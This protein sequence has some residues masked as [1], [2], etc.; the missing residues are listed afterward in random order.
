M[1]IEYL[2]WSK[3]KVDIL[4]Y[5]IFKEEWLSARELENQLKQSFPAIKKQLDNLEQAGIILKNK[6][7]NR[8]QIKIVEDVKPLILRIF[9]FDMVNFLK[10]LVREYSFLEKFL[11]WDLFFSDL[12]QKIWVDLVFIYNNDV[13]EIFLNDV[14]QKIWD[15][16]DTYFINIVVTFMKKQDYE[17]RLKYADKFVLMLTKLNQ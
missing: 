1:N 4:R 2:F 12:T 15:F 14:K 7:W 11:L 6:N 9:I 5:L 10:D 3:T 8:W 17:R 13:E 16:F